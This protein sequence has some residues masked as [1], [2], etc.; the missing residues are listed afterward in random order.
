MVFKFFAAF[1]WRKKKLKFCL[2]SM[3]TLVLKTLTTNLFKMAVRKP[4]VILKSNTLTPFKNYL[5]FPAASPA[6]ETFYRITGGFLNAA[7][8]ILLRLS[9][10]SPALISVFMFS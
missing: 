2:A 9:V 3:Q 5:N 8:T 4:P 1:L 7:T 10:K 6:Y